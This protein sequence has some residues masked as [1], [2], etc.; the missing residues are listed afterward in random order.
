MAFKSRSRKTRSVHHS[1]ETT[2][3]HHSDQGEVWSEIAHLQ[4]SA[5]IHSPTSAMNDVFKAREDDLR[6]CQ[7]IF[8]PV[9][10]Q[11]G[12]IALLDGAPAG[13]DV[14]SLT[15]A[16]AKIHPKLVRSYTLDGLLDAPKPGEGGLT[17]RPS[18][19]AH[20]SAD[21]ATQARQFFDEIVAAEDREFP[22][23]GFGTDHRF[24][25][26]ALAGS[27]LVYENEVIHAAFFRLDE[28]EQTERMTSY[29]NRRRHYFD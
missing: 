21:W 3:F 13:V 24:K 11:V 27:A 28:T 14:V 23:I 20:Q 8:K 26:K 29:R 9:P 1:L 12:L 2:G 10:N 6:K 18:T 16:Y 22:S 15:G 7:D 5:G 19:L 4:E 25:G 17:S